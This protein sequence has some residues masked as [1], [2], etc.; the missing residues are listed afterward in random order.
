MKQEEKI[1]HILDK[2]NVYGPER[3]EAE[4]MIIELVKNE[5]KRVTM[6]KNKLN[7]CRKELK[8]LK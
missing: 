4:D 8:L 1:W 5:K 2:F 3:Q 6:F 7:N